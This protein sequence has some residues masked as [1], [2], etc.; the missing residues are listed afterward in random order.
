LNSHTECYA[1]CTE[2]KN[3]LSKY[4]KNCTMWT[5]VSVIFRPDEWI[6]KIIAIVA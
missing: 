1:N 4:E 2:A 3:E 6:W 5:L